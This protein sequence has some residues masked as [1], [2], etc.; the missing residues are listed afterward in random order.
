MALKRWHQRYA[1]VLP[2]LR[3][4]YRYIESLGLMD[5]PQIVSVVPERVES[6]REQAA[7]GTP[8]PDATAISQE[9]RAAIAEFQSNV[10]RWKGL[11]E[12][13]KNAHS[14][15]DGKAPTGEAAPVP[16]EEG[17]VSEDDWEDVQDG[18][19]NVLETYGVHL[20]DAYKEATGQAIPRLQSIVRTCQRH[21]GSAE[22]DSVLREA[23]DIN[24]DIVAICTQYQETL[25]DGE[26]RSAFDGAQGASSSRQTAEQQGGPTASLLS[27]NPMRMIKDPT[28]PRDRATNKSKEQKGKTQTCRRRSSDKAVLEKLAKVAPVVASSGFARVWDSNAPPIY[29]GSHVMEVSNHWG[30]VDVHQELPKDRLDA[31]FLVDQSN[32]QYTKHPGEER[33]QP[34]RKASIQPSSSPKEAKYREFSI[35]GSS[36][37]L[38]SKEKRKAERL[39]NEQI[40]CEASQPAHLSSLEDL[41]S[42]VPS[43]RGNTRIKHKLSVQ[44]RLTKKLKLKK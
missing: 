24:S 23:A 38:N 13:L 22:A 31:L 40:L 1:E 14:I 19:N 27:H 3:I 8:T 42:R 20:L 17:D 16:P 41:P 18:G 7:E 39:Y 2:R 15:L 32:I 36:S 26:L 35:F 9:L 10:L 28:A 34:P 21:V 30:P 29:A 25:S 43:G 5:P 33:C 6:R 37:T 44:Q 4:A 12:E 11:V